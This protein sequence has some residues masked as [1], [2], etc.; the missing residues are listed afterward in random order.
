MGA[1]YSYFNTPDPKILEQI[2][3]ISR[4]VVE[5]G[6]SSHS[7]HVRGCTAELWKSS[8]LPQLKLLSS[9]TVERP[10]FLLYKVKNLDYKVRQNL[11]GHILEAYH[12]DFNYQLRNACRARQINISYNCNIRKAREISEKSK[13]CL[14]SLCLS[15]SCMR[16][17]VP[18]IDPCTLKYYTARKNA[19]DMG[20]SLWVYF[21]QRYKKPMV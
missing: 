16:K 15:T 18:P 5:H 13:F 14:N 11:V 7:K 9:I 3:I 4:Q 6:K 1:Y 19:Q 8:V 20:I 21:A 12:D 17:H 10:S 2:S